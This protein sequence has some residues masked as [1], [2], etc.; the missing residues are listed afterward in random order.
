[1]SLVSLGHRP[2]YWR[3]ALADAR[4][5][6]FSGSGAGSFD[7]WWRA[8]G[9]LPVSVRDAHSLYL[10]TLAEL[11]PVGLALLLVALALPL[12]ALKRGGWHPDAAAPAAAY[13][14]WL[15]HAGLDWDWEVA[16]TTF[17]ALACATALLTSSD[18]T[19]GSAS[20]R[21]SAVALRP[22]HRAASGAALR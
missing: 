18:E 9:T 22:G 7:D 15:V 19:A 5:A 17:A 4:D 3:A 16:V 11:G 6:P 20:A 14:A 2:S 21:R 10:E 12:V 1:L 13:A 8:H